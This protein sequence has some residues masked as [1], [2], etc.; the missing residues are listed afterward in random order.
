VRVVNIE[1]PV[2]LYEL[3]PHGAEIWLD[4]KTRYEQ[5]LESYEQGKFRPAARMLGSLLAQH[6]DDAPALLLLAR[7]VNAM[8]EEPIKFSPVWDLPGK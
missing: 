6:P 3:V 5:A 1:K 7:A 2:N 8:V 4:V